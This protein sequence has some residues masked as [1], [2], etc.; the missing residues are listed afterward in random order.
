M[1]LWATARGFRVILDFVST[2]D[3]Q[4][5]GMIMI[6]RLKGD[7]DESYLLNV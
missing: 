2:T 1:P 4:R 5:E 6:G 7:S 3:S